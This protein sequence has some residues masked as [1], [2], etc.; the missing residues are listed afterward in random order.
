MV[1]FDYLGG[2]LT[3]PG[4]LLGRNPSDLENER[5]RTGAQ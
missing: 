1:L 4:I 3:R 5:D 2:G